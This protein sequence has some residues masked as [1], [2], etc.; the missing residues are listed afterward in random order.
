MATNVNVKGRGFVKRVRD[1]VKSNYD[2][3]DECE[4]CASAQ[5][6]ELHHFYSVS[7]MCGI[8]LKNKGVVIETDEQSLQYRDEFIE[9][10]WDKLVNECATLCNTHHKKLHKIYGAKPTLATGPKQGRWVI[11]QKAKHESVSKA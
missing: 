4:I 9:D 11:K 1:R 8:W 7:Q 3:A 5:D 2:R 10:H 6:V